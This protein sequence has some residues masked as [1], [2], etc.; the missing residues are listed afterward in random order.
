MRTYPRNSP[1]AAARIVALLLV[2][3]GHVC[4][5]EIE[6]VRQLDFER[7]LGLQPGGFARVVQTLCEDLLA[8]A[9]G[10][11]ALCS[12]DAATLGSIMGELDDPALQTKVLRVAS[13]AAAADDHLAGSEA[14][15]L[16][17]ARWHWRLPF[18]FGVVPVAVPDSRVGAPCHP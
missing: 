4:Q 3:D 15:L 12:L 16:D 8:S 11:G 7:Q 5:S 14:M 18:D 17:A 2:S 6:A 1:E 9:C 13:A 10:G